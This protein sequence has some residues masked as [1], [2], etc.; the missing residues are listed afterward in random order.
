MKT[1][2]GVEVLAWTFWPIRVRL[3]PPRT[4]LRVF[5]DRIRRYSA[6]KNWLREMKFL[7][8]CG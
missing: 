6:V 1:G 2:N 3:K 4:V 5:G 7:G 8:N